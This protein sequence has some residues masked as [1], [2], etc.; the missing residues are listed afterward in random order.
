MH[1]VAQQHRQKHAKMHKA[2][3]HAHCRGCH[4]CG[5]MPLGM[6]CRF[7]EV[8]PALRRARVPVHGC[9]GR[10][11]IIEHCRHVDTRPF[12]VQIISTSM[13][14]MLN[15]CKNPFPRSTE[16]GLVWLQSVVYVTLTTSGMQHHQG[17]SSSK[18]FA[19][20]FKDLPE[21]RRQHMLTRLEASSMQSSQ[22]ASW[23][24]HGPPTL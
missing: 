7:S 10:A 16:D 14:L 19:K 18:G 22:R 12:I 4:D 3:T 13:A 8:A 15:R 1:A 17:F 11:C 6:G 23:A 2:F 5:A 20:A 9:R 24:A 21:C